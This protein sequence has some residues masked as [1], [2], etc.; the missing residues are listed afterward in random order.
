[1]NF[2]DVRTDAHEGTT[3]CFNCGSSNLERKDLSQAF[4]YGSGTSAVELKANMP[5]YT[6]ID[7]GY[8]FAGPEAE[9]ARHEAVC[10]HLG[11]MT[12]NEIVA[13]RESTGLSRTEFAER[14]GVGIASLKRWETGALVQN[15]ANDQLIYLMTIPENVEHLQ[16]RNR[17]E[18]MDTRS[19]AS[20]IVAAPRHM[21]VIPFRGRSLRTDSALEERAA[22]W[23]LRA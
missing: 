5:V 10:R 21:S 13:V 15:A 7:C 17:F 2:N 16:R 18:P 14:T 4:Q 19:L 9:D 12:P 3:A 23:A 20:A 6:C 11:V 1:M 22:Q 8:Q